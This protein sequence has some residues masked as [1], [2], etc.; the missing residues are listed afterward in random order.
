MP[1]RQVQVVEQKRVRNLLYR[2]VA[3]ILGRQKGE[4]Q[5][6]HLRR[7]GM[8]YVHDEMDCALL[9]LHSCYWFRGGS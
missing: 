9:R 4:R 5:G 8:G 1:R 2:D 3:Y 6:R 7:E